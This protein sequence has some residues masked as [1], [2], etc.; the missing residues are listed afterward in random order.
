MRGLV[1]LLF[2]LLS[3]LHAAAERGDG[4][5]AG[6]PG[7]AA[8]PVMQAVADMASD[9]G[10]ARCC[11]S[12]AHQGFSCQSLTALPGILTLAAPATAMRRM[13]GPPA[14]HLPRG[15]EPALDLRPPIAL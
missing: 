9:E 2:V 14:R 10:M 8:M 3:P 11:D 1:I 6:M 4:G 13:A 12:G 7:M 5:M 15:Y